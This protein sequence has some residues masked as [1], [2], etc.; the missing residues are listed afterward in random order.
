MADTYLTSTELSWDGYGLCMVASV[1][2]GLL[3]IEISFE[4]PS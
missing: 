1:K 3:L 4:T 2:Y